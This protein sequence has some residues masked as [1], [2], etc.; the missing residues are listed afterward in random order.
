MMLVLGLFSF[1]TVA[2]EAKPKDLREVMQMISADMLQIVRGISEKNFELIADKA[3]SVAYHKEPPIKQRQ[4]L[5]LELGF[6]LPKF[7]GHDNDVHSA[8]MAMKTAAEKL[9][10]AGVI[11][12]YGKALNACVACHDNYRERIKAVKW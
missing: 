11:E 10:M 12:N 6:E 3:K 2:E 5:L 7:K 4:A 9:D 1:S 8:S